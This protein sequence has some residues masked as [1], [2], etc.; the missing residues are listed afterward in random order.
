MKDK[1]IAIFTAIALTLTIAVIIAWSIQNEK[2][3]TKEREMIPL[4]EIRKREADV[5]WDE[6]EIEEISID[7]EYTFVTEHK[8]HSEIKLPAELQ[9]FTKEKC[10]EY[11]ANYALILALMESES[12]FRK[13]VGNEQILGGEEG[14]PRY[15]GYM[16]LSEGKIREA[17]KE[18]GIDAHTPEGNI[19]MGIILMAKYHQKYNDTE[20]ELTAYKAGEGAADT[21][22][23]LGYQHI[24][25]RAEYFE[26][27]IKETEE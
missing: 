11:G 6:I 17:R 3:R 2:E 7:D 26:N 16:Q 25:K 4:E 1:R 15:Y 18:Y 8:A 19:E 21:G 10:D 9:I 23:R 27:L 5:E 14:G 13:E 20:A 24:I 12:T 22:I